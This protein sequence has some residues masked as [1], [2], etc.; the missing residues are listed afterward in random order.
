MG[1]PFCLTYE[2]KLKHALA[3]QERAETP[4]DHN[5][6]FSM[7]DK[8]SAERP[9]HPV[10]ICGMGTALAADLDQEALHSL[11]TDGLAEIT[12]ETASLPTRQA[13]VGEHKAVPSPRG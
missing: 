10:P 4:Q 2:E 6:C 11:V 1:R 8:L 9:D 13:F 5:R 12:G 7:W 3:I